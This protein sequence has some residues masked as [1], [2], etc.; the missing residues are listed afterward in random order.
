MPVFLSHRKADKASALKIYAY[1]EAN[2]IKC[3]IDEFDEVLQRS[4]NIASPAEF[5]GDYRLG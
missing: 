3:Y 2:K 5:M 1:L 4:K